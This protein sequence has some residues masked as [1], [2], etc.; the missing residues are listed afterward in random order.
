MMYTR[1][2]LQQIFNKEEATDFILA[3][4]GFGTAIEDGKLIDDAVDEFGDVLFDFL[5]KL[6]DNANEVIESQI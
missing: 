1:N 4:G 3:I 5:K 6:E 2:A